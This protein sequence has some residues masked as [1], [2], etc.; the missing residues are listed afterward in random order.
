MTSQKKNCPHD[1]KSRVKI[2][3]SSDNGS[4][5][6]TRHLAV[7]V[8]DFGPFAHGCITHDTLDDDGRYTKN[9]FDDILNK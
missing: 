2:M 7:D 1:L 5:S 8:Y 3:D 4:N 6:G 9:T